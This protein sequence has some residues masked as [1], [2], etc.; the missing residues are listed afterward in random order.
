MRVLGGFFFAVACGTKRPCWHFRCRLTVAAAVVVRDVLCGVVL[1]LLL[2]QGLVVNGTVQTASLAMIYLVD[3]V[4]LLM[5]RP[6]SNSV[7]QWLET[8][9]VRY[10][11]YVCM[12]SCKQGIRDA[13]TNTRHH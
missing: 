11:V 3:I 7:V 6:F 12:C 13:R 4:L 9:L 8:V 2:Y 5:L 10:D 1:L